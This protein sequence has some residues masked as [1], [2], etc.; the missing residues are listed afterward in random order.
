[1]MRNKLAFMLCLGVGLLMVINP[2]AWADD[3]DPSKNTPQ[4]TWVPPISTTGQRQLTYVND[5]MGTIMNPPYDVGDFSAPAS[6]GET[7]SLS[8]YGGKLL[9]VYFGYLTCPDVCPTTLADMM[10]AY[11]EV[12][13]TTD[14]VQV[15]FIT[16]DPERDTL[17]RIGKFVTAFHPDFL[18]LRPEDDTEVRA[19]A[20]L[21]GVEYERREVDSSVEYLFD[22]SAAVFM[23]GPDG[24][25]ISQY[26]FGVPYTEMVNDLKV[27]RNYLIA[28]DAYVVPDKQQVSID[29]SREYRIVIPEGTGDLIQMG[30]DPGIIPLNIELILGEKD[31]IVLENHDYRDYL[32]GGIWVAPHETTYKQFYEPQTFIGLCTITVGSDL[33][34]IIVR[35]PES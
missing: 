21:F 1:M 33:V 7:F 9:M 3:P 12:E 16:V 24:R 23:I 8:D 13:A 25:I 18:G 31:V 22:H 5:L 2:V 10:R 34:E 30:Q 4:P 29:P 26:P 15:L 11:R 27:L 28:P 35:E 6:N 19:L 17:E 20:T 14:E 32:V